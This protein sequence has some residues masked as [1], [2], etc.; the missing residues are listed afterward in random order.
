[1]VDYQNQKVDPNRVRIIAGGNLINYPGELTTRSADLITSKI[2]WNSVLSTERARYMWLDITI[3]YLCAPLKRYEYM[4]IKL[5]NFPDHIDIVQQYD[6]ARKAKNGSVYI[7]IRQSIYG[8]PQS[9]RLAN[10]F[11]Q[12][13][14]RPKGYYEDSHTSAGPLEICEPPY[15]IQPRSG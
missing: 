10:F 2:L 11:L 6:L 3:F 15:P 4:Q 9:G 7:K 8:L 12:E 14:L 5:S 13:K 1:M